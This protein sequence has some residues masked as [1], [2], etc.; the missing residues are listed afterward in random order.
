M[1]GISIERFLQVARESRTGDIRISAGDDK[2]LVNK[3]TLGH[4][5]AT[6]LDMGNADTRDDRTG[7]AIDKFR[8][9]LVDRYGQ[10][11]GNRA[12]DEALAGARTDGAFTGQLVMKAADL[13]LRMSYHDRLENKQTIDRIVGDSGLQDPAKQVFKERF[14]Q[15]LEART[16]FFRLRLPDFEETALTNTIRQ[17]VTG[18]MAAEDT[19]EKSNAARKALSEA[20]QSVMVSITNNK[21]PDVLLPQLLEVQRLEQELMKLEEHDGQNGE[22]KTQIAT[23]QALRN[24][25]SKYR[26]FVGDLHRRSLSDTSP[27]R[28]IHVAAKEIQDDDSSSHEQKMQARTLATQ[29]EALFSNISSATMR[30][31]S[32]S[33]EADL[34][35][36][37]EAGSLKPQSLD[38][39]RTALA[40]IFEQWSGETEHCRGFLGLIR[41][42]SSHLV[43]HED[44][45]PR[46]AWDSPDICRR[47]ENSVRNCADDDKI[48]YD[49]A[50]KNYR[51]GIERDQTLHP[52]LKA[53]LLSALD[54]LEAE[55]HL[56]HALGSA[57]QTANFPPE[58]VWRL[59]TPGQQDPRA[60]KWDMEH[61]VQGSYASRCRAWIDVLTSPSELSG[62]R[63]GRLHEI[64][65]KDNVRQDELRELYGKDVNPEA[66]DK[67]RDD[68]RLKGGFRGG[69]VTRTL[70]LNTDF[71]MAGGKEFRDY[72]GFNPD[73]FLRPNLE[74]SDIKFSSW[75]GGPEE[76]RRRADTILNDA[77][78]EIA[79]KLPDEQRYAIADVIQ[80]LGRSCLF[81]EDDTQTLVLMTNQLLLSTGQVPTILEDPTRMIGLSR[82]E[83]AEQIKAGQ[84]LYR[85]IRG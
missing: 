73:W 58:N 77:W 70:E 61:D 72:I 49:E 6:A 66:M 64:A 18:L 26:D 78:N 52:G 15:A 14:T 25:L 69:E 40:P 13:A 21:S 10:D 71:S 38:T 41:M 1:S 48:S 11:V 44:G 74:G 81:N 50:I 67:A 68:N 51:T 20:L 9:A 27:L 75:T 19:L 12:L 45:P 33:R 62:E 31:L 85:E 28:A 23:N 16:D 43:E 46:F 32:E 2:Q 36:F 47:L 56:A 55:N 54:A 53:K 8:A 7:I 84:D 63:L 5:L 37:K 82:D 76:C 80:Q 29:C 4:R 65:I 34:A 79:R 59:M 35:R 3:G 60:S 42:D 83:F 17:Q 22:D 39:A 24:Q 57:R 30:P